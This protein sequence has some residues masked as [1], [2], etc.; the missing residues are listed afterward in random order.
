M[1]NC[2]IVVTPGVVVTTPRTL[3]RSPLM[4]SSTSRGSDTSGANQTP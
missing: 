3:L 1:P 2:V 4:M